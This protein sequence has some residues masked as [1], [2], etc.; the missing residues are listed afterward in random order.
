MKI[1]IGGSAANPPTMGHLH[2]IQRIMLMDFDM[3]IWIPCGA[4]DDKHIEVSPDDRVAMTELMI[5]DNLRLSSRPK[6]VV[7]YSDIYSDE[8]IK[9][10]VYVRRLLEKYPDARITWFTGNDQNVSQWYLGR[11]IEN[12]CDI[13]YIRRVGHELVPYNVDFNLGYEYSST[14]V[15]DRL[16]DG[17]SISGIVP[18]LVESYIKQF[19]LYKGIKE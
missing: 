1:A 9:S 4:R 5:D 16:E 19:G 15:R 6:L 7:D 13:L 8:A 11:E 2:L 17:L 10:I 3:V 12:V 18:P 14:E